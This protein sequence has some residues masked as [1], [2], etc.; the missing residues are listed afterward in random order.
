M[1][2][3]RKR[4]TPLVHDDDQLPSGIVSN[5]VSVRFLLI[6]LSAAYEMHP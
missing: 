1:L 2:M 3:R 4:Q 6:R 5:D